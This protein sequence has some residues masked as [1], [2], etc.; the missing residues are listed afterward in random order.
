MFKIGVEAFG[1]ARAGHA[2]PLQGGDGEMRDGGRFRRGV[3]TP[4]YARILSGGRRA[5]SPLAAVEACGGGKLPGRFTFYAPH[6]SSNRIRCNDGFC[7]CFYGG[8]GAIET[9]AG[10]ADEAVVDFDAHNR[11]TVNYL[12]LVDDDFLNQRV[13]QLLVQLRN[14]GILTN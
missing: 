1:S 2:R 5:A 13:N 10:F 12:F 9:I 4:P 7:F 11:F 14:I 3:G 6:S 8:Y